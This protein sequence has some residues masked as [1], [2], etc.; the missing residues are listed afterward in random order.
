MILDNETLFSDSQAITADC[1][2]TNI[3]KLNGEVAFG[4]PVELFVQIMEAFKSAE[5]SS[6]TV[7]VQTSDNEAFTSP[8]DLVSETLSSIEAG[9]KANLKFLPKGNK[10]YIRLYYDV[11]FASD[12]SALTQGK[13]T[14]GIVEGTSETY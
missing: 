7:K 5:A 10:G 1:A 4:T 11:N 9:A 8:K 3:V 13:I 2:S 12:A 6:L 14:A